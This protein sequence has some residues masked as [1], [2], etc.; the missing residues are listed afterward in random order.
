MEANY[1]AYKLI[2]ELLTLD[3]K[4]LEPSPLNDRLGNKSNDARQVLPPFP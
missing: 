3:F 4:Q 2:M 1:L